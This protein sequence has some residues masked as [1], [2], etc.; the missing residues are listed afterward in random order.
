M[1]R[2][3]SVAEV[4]AFVKGLVTEASPMTFPENAAIDI[5]NLVL[6]RDGSLT[7]RIGMDL[8]SNFLV[9]NSDQPE[10]QSFAV[11]SFSWKSPGGY[12][13]SE[14]AVVQT[15]SLLRFF[16][17]TKVPLSQQTLASFTMNATPDVK[18]S[19]ASSDGFL[20]V[21]DG[22]GTVFTFDYDGVS[23]SQSTGRLLIRDFFGVED[24]ASGINLLEGN[25]ISTRPNARTDP[26][27]YNLRNQTF[28][29]P[30]AYGGGEAL[31]DPVTTFFEEWGV[32][33]A[34]SDNLV[35]Y[36]YADANDSDDRNIRRYFG[37]DNYRNPLGSNRA[38]M[39]Y[40]IIDAMNRGASR[41]AGIA[42]MHQQY[43]QLNFP[44]SSLPQD[45]TPGGASCVASYA[46]RIFYSGFTS[47]TIGGD[48]QSP[49]MGSY[50]LFS[51][52]VQ[53]SA[54]IYK[55]YQEGDPTSSE[56]P[57]L[58]DTDGGFLRLDGAYNIQYMVNVGDAL[59][60]IA[61]NGVWKITGGSGYGFKA[62]DYLTSK[63][64]EHG[65]ISANS[66]VVVDN[67]FMYWADDGIYH[68]VQNQYGDWQ[69]TN[70]TATTIQTLFDSIPYGTKKLC[71]GLYDSYQRRVRWL[72]Y[73]TPEQTELAK[74]L[75]LDI[76][77]GAFYNSTIFAQNTVYPK[78]LS[79]VKVPPF[80]TTVQNRQ[81]ITSAGDPVITS[82]GNR[83]VA[84]AETIDSSLSEIYY[85]V[86]TGAEAGTSR[87]TFSYYRD[88][89][90]RDWVSYNGVGADAEAYVVTGW[91]GMGDFQRQKQVTYLTV[92]AI[93]TE[94]GFDSNFLPVN[95]SS[96]KV[97]GQWG[98]TDSAESG[99]WTQE[100]EAYRHRRLWIPENSSSG[101]DDGEHVI[102]TKNKLRGKGRVISLKFS[103]SP[104]RAFHLLGWSYLG[105]MNGT[106]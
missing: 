89:S 49:R 98:W 2:Q 81:I 74:E 11:T 22:G 68:V 80:V 90:W 75:I 28:G 60:V 73:N 67:T 43:S 96:I 91:S 101:Y 94:T 58:V 84:S 34:N 95:S 27:V 52:L 36:L 20:I 33:Q 10:G 38:P 62:T 19:F 65:S 50:V 1:A 72:Y 82:P 7:R 45:R 31:R 13:E 48:S 25:G 77:L 16:D 23:I 57:D 85:L 39:G 6:N 97:Q 92:Y 54:D 63:V 69:A 59:M 70:L 30:R 12:S 87:Y 42:Y 61:E 103:S 100:F 29:V 53:S 106:V 3:Q 44:V 21:V 35:V 46:G 40:F 76:N 9:L 47:Q 104:N 26:H 24:Y 8:E 99:K 37:S 32:L 56:T 55:C 4:N 18:M 102:T 17:A 51:R 78:V 83:V 71:Q 14:I 86:T 64:T 41:L 93:K 105:S 66:V 88:T 15:G 5:Q 79:M